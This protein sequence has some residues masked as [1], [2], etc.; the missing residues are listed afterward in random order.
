MLVE[1][2]NIKHLTLLRVF[3]TVEYKMRKTINSFVLTV[4]II[5]RKNFNQHRNIVLNEGEYL[6]N[7]NDTV[8]VRNREF[9]KDKYDE[10]EFDWIEKEYSYITNGHVLQGALYERGKETQ[11]I[12]EFMNI[13][14]EFYTIVKIAYNFD[15]NGYFIETTNFLEWVS[16]GMIVYFDGENLI[17]STLEE[18]KE[19]YIVT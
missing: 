11:F 3:C 15:K 4:T 5:D 2:E 7:K 6:V 17:K 16:E 9:L 19:N 13:L 1:L 18:I 10:I 8:F 12:K 14:P